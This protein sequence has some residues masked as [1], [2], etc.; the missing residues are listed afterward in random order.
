MSRRTQITLTDDQYERLRA[1]SER[2]GVSL[3]ELIRRAVD[4]SYGTAKHD[5]VLEALEDSFGSWSDQ[6]GD[7]AAYVDDLRRGMARRLADT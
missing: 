2:T 5:T 7:G 4:R 6:T 3:A 1:E